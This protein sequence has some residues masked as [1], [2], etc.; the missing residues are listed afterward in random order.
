MA[1]GIY[2]FHIAVL[3]TLAAG[4]AALWRRQVALGDEARRC[5]NRV[6]DMEKRLEPQI[7]NRPD[8]PNRCGIN[9]LDS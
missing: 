2:E 5:L 3:S 8:C 7:C 9:E 6:I 4:F 1:M